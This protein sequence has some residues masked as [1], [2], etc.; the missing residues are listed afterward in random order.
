MRLNSSTSKSREII[1]MPPAVQEY[2]EQEKRAQESHV[3]VAQVKRN[4]RDTLDKVQNDIFPKMLDR[5]HQLHVS[6]DMADDL[7]ESSTL[8][9][10]QTQPHWRQ[11][12]RQWKPPIW[13]WPTWMFHWCEC[14]CN[15][16][17][18][19]RRKKVIH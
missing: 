13:W 1:P 3:K 12:I 16:C 17:Y 11:W 4:V 5:G 18:R 9:L 10:H 2:F 8:F 6:V 14:C 7:E 15:K 19:K